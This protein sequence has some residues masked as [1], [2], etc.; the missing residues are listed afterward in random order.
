MSLTAENIEEIKNRFAKTE[1]VEDLAILLSWIY[2]LKYPKQNEK[3]PV[4]IEAKHLNYYAFKAENRYKQFSIPKKSGGTRTISAPRYKLKTIQKCINEVLNAIFTPHF[5][6][7]GFV[8]KKSILDNAKLHT[9]KQFVYNTDLKDFFPSVDFRR[10][11]SV[12]G[13]K[14][15]NLINENGTQ[16]K[17]KEH[18]AFLIANLC[19]ENGSLPQGAPTSPTL[20]NVVCQRLDKNLFKFAKSIKATY[21]RYADDITFSA[22]KPIFDAEFNKKLAE[23]IT[24]ENFKINEAKTRLQKAGEQQSVTGIVVNKKPNVDRNFMK[25]IRFWLMCWTKFETE[26]T[27]QKFLVQFPDKKGFLRYGGATPQ[28]YNYLNGKILFF[29]MVRGAN[30]A[31]FLK[32]KTVFDQLYN[33]IKGKNSELLTENISENEIDLGLI[34]DIWEK[35]GIGRRWKNLKHLYDGKYNK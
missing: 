29:G 17:G 4:I 13:L 16:T 30:D 27:Q 12:L 19:C 1:T 14:P 20:T 18:L 23:I 6:A 32:F 25:D 9:G 15:F 31:L 7:T 21:S 22:N 2:A 26:A 28:F 35:E 11:K 5:T 8:P 10:I 34:L 33:Q 3:T 24:K